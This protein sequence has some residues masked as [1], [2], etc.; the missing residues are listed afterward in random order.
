MV[1][2]NFNVFCTGQAPAKTQS[3]LLIDSDAELTI[4]VSFQG[5]QLIARRYAEISQ[6]AISSCLSLRL[7]MASIF[8]RDNHIS[9][10]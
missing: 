5:F 1:I 2:D 10:S 3:V 4:A 8:S 9:S 6:P 7:A